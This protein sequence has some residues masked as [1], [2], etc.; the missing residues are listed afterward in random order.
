MATAKT[1]LGEVAPEALGV[2]LPHEH[3]VLS[4]GG[5]RLDM[6]GYNVPPLADEVC[7]DL[8]AAVRTFGI[9]TVVD[10]GPAELGRDVVLQREVARRLGINIIAATGF[11]KQG[12]G[13]PLY[14]QA[15]ELDEVE[16]HLVR[17]I[18]EGVGPDRVRCGVIKLATTDAPIGPAEEKMFH[19]AARASKRTGCPIITHTDPAGW[20][21]GN[22]GLRQ[23]EILLSEGVDPARIAIGHICGTSNMAYLVDILRRGVSIAFDRV[24]SHR[25]VPDE[26]RAALVAGLCA[27]GY[28]AQVFLS[29]DHQGVWFPKRPAAL[30]ASVKHFGYLHQMFLP[31]LR[32][33]GVRE[34]HIVQMTE[35]NPQA[36]LA[37]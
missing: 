6:P 26:V 3:I 19:A 15:Q 37:F 30:A 11:Y 21:V 1:V 36:L 17:E 2:T 28:A 27:S 9:K 12:G 29:M 5:A 14:W 25:I 35:A 13:L 4:Y 16:D 7:K 33:G 20:V 34:E 8:G 10:A 32:A 22:I 24:G 23:T 18:T 31:R